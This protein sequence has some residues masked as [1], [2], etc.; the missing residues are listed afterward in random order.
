MRQSHWF[1]IFG[2]LAGLTACSEPPPENLCAENPSC[3]VGP[4]DA[5]R[6]VDGDTFQIE[7]RRFRLIG[8]DSPETSPHAECMAEADLGL[9]AEAAIQEI[10]SEADD[11]Q[12]LFR[13]VDEY[14]RAR[15]HL[16]LDGLHVGYLMQQRGLAKQWDEDR[17]E[18]K[19]DWCS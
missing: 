5:V 12:I 19:P 7:G 2:L 18:A 13:G 15:A 4:A 9:E 6:P 14:G 1:V 11:V 3:L 10:F 16:Y 8:Y 17:S